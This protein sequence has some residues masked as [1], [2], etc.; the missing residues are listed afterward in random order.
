MSW[1][2]SSAKLYIFVMENL[3]YPQELTRN[4]HIGHDEHI[5][6]SRPLQSESPATMLLQ[7]LQDFGEFHLGLPAELLLSRSGGG[8]GL[9]SSNSHVISN[10]EQVIGQVHR[11]RPS[12]SFFDIWGAV[13]QK[14]E[15]ASAGDVAIN[16]GEEKPEMVGGS[17]EGALRDAMA[18]MGMSEQC[19]KGGCT[20]KNVEEGTCPSGCKTETE[21]DAVAQEAEKCPFSGQACA[22]GCPKLSCPG[23]GGSA[24][25]R[26]SA[27]G[28][29]G[30]LSTPS[31]LG[32]C[33]Q[34][35]D[36]MFRGCPL[37]GCPDVIQGCVEKAKD[38][39]PYSLMP[40][41]STNGD[42]DIPYSI[43]TGRL[44]MWCDDPAHPENTICVKKL[45][46]DYCGFANMQ[47]GKSLRLGWKELITNDGSRTYYKHVKDPPDGLFTFQFQPQPSVMSTLDNG[48][49]VAD[50]RKLGAMES[51]FGMHFPIA[52]DPDTG[53]DSVEPYGRDGRS[54]L[55]F[56]K[57]K[58]ADDTCCAT[59]G[60]KL[61]AGSVGP[62]HPSHYEQCSHERDR[63]FCITPREYMNYLSSGRK[64]WVDCSAS[65]EQGLTGCSWT[66]KMAGEEWGDKPP[67]K[68]T[69]AGVVQW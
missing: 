63:P 41:N 68:L 35:H 34:L 46:G 7:Y 60:E 11:R 61:P 9:P 25:Q 20:E 26:G 55:A 10:S 2:R 28:G 32:A 39:K 40:C 1:K 59:H 23:Y 29:G 58:A 6:R 65:K 30:L 15:D 64:L 37:E 45:P 33:P 8:G 53:R 4:E 21:L 13:G 47:A 50:R 43:G 56:A 31:A 18:N 5:R 27:A 69:P 66:T 3:S 12:S 54:V 17:G 62:D 49:A 16:P 14:K 48:E 19:P 22:P 38:R 44:G 36:P 24:A 57:R 42:P 51:R 67:P 52:Q